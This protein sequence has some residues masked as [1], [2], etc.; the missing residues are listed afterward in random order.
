MFMPKRGISVTLS[1]DNLLWLKART[2]AAKARSLSETLDGL[3]TDARLAGRIPDALVRSVVGTVDVA[4][5][6]PDLE[7][8]DTYLRELFASSTARSVPA[9]ERRARYTATPRG[10]RRG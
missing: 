8:A 9:R 2:Q 7:R 1:D 4:A 5:D 3:V 10:R 6:D